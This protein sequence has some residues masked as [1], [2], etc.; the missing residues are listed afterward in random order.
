MEYLYMG[1]IALI[2]ALLFLLYLWK[3]RGTASKLPRLTTIGLI[4][5]VLGIAFSD[6][7]RL[8][9]YSFFGIAI[10]LSITD[11]VIIRKNKERSI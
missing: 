11:I 8:I 10:L 5:I 9:S 1:I 4:L 3:G 2:V 6:T 7:G